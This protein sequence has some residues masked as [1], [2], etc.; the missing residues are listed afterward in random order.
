MPYKNASEAR[1]TGEVRTRLRQLSQD[2]YRPPEKGSNRM[3]VTEYADVNAVRQAAALERIATALEQLVLEYITANQAP[4]PNE[5]AA[6]LPPDQL[7]PIGQPYVPPTA[8]GTIPQP[9]IPAPVYVPPAPWI[10]PVHGQVKTVPPG[11]SKRT[12]QPYVAFLAC[13][14]AG[15]NQKPPR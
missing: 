15:C 8:N 10:C 13:P 4:L 14:V 3:T 12:G 2:P 9:Y 6:D 5:F 11:V 7:A 1:R